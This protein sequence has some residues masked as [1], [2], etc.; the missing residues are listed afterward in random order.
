MTIDY[1]MFHLPAE[2]DLLFDNKKLDILKYLGILYH[3]KVNFRKRKL[4]FEQL[5]YYNSLLYAENKEY[6]IPLIY[7]YLKDKKRTNKIIINLENLGFIQ[8]QGDIYTSTNKLKI[9]IT[10]KGI[11]EIDSWESENVKMQLEKIYIIMKNYPYDNKS[12]K[13]KDLLYE[14]EH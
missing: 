10:K 3:S 13:F 2:I 6:D 1:N 5:L 11:E 4:N 9:S 8:I 14:G 7:K 12:I